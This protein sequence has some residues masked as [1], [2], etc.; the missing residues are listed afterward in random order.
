MNAPSKRGLRSTIDGGID[1]AKPHIFGGDNT[2]S[3][4]MIHPFDKS[5]APGW[6]KTVVVAVLTFLGCL[7]H[8]WVFHASLQNALVVGTSPTSAADLFIR[9]LLVGIVAGTL[10]AITKMWTYESTL[11]TYVYP[12][13]TLASV[14]SREIGLIPAAVSM[15]IQFCGY[16]AAG[17]ILKAI[18]TTGAAQANLVNGGGVALSGTPAVLLWFGTTVIVFNYLYNMKFWNNDGRAESQYHAS[19]R[20]AKSTAVCIFLITI[21]FGGIGAANQRL[22]SY[23]SGLYVT[24]VIINRL[25]A[26]ATLN[27]VLPLLASAATGAVLYGIVALLIYG[28]ERKSGSSGSGSSEGT[29]MEF[30]PNAAQVNSS[31]S[32]YASDS[33]RVRQRKQQGGVQVTY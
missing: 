21:A 4:W 25:D 23:T 13:I 9:I 28:D 27:I 2:M 1:H 18:I 32:A 33:Q 5:Y 12:E 29:P 22:V 10:Y 26:G 20:S 19:R 17:G 8:G 11:R 31:A 24:G 3:S 7:V 6:L 16:L 15:G 14:V 30:A